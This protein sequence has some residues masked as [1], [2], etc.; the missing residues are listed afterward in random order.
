M[1]DQMKAMASTMV[2]LLFPQLRSHRWKFLKRR[3]QLCSENGP[4]ER[5]ARVQECIAG[6]L[7]RP[8]KLRF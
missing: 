2:M 3:T 7:A 6:D 4:L 1:G 8:T 5:T